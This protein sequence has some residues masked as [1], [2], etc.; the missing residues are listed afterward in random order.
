[1]KHI[2]HVTRHKDSKSCNSLKSYFKPVES[3]DSD[4]TVE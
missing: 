2:E 1:M 3:K 4:K